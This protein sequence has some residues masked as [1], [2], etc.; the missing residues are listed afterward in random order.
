MRATTFFLPVVFL[1]SVLAWGR[2]GSG[3]KSSINN[4]NQ[5]FALPAENRR[6]DY[7]QSLKKPFTYNGAMPFWGNHG[8]KSFLAAIGHA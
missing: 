3:T 4:N 2:E 6:Y 5:E 8:S 1:S 7:K